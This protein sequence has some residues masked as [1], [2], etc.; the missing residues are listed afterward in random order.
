MVELNSAV[1]DQHVASHH[2]RERGEFD[3]APGD[4]VDDARDGAHGS[5]AL[6]LCGERLIVT[7]RDGGDVGTRA[8]LIDFALCVIKL[9]HYAFK[10]VEFEV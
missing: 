3:V 4:V 7:A 8:A 9:M 1:R 2:E 5:H 6:L 10:P